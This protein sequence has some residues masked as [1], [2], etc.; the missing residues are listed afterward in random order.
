MP[1]AIDAAVGDHAEADSLRGEIAPR[2]PVLR[3]QVRVIALQ[4]GV[5]LNF[6]NNPGP[7]MREGHVIPPDG[8]DVGRVSPS[9]AIHDQIDGDRLRYHGL[10]AW[11]DF[12][13]NQEIPFK[14]GFVMKLPRRIPRRQ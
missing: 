12:Q 2:R 10:D 3:G 13:E 6:E 14:L 9:T 8:K 4:D 11:I 7:A 5:G 1:G